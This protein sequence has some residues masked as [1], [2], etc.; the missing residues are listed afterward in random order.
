MSC[1]A[2][3]PGS[4][5]S[6]TTGQGSPPPPPLPLEP[7]SALSHHPPP[8]SATHSL[9]QS[10]HFK[11]C[12]GRPG[13]FDQCM[14]TQGRNRKEKSMPL[15]DH[16][17]SLLR[18]Q[19]RAMETQHSRLGQPSRQPSQLPV[20]GRLWSTACQAFVMGGPAA[21]DPPSSGRSHDTRQQEQE[22]SRCLWQ[23]A[24]H[25][26]AYCSTALQH[27][28]ASPGQLGPAEASSA[29]GRLM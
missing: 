25:S 3:R 14:E 19:P 10:I 5:G 11:G 15:S 26:M 21:R 28:I 29:T 18:Q 4:P 13:P 12:W 16:N 2:G 20:A 9:G 1:L 27:R 24:D 17:R 22:V 6:A 7:A 23:A 8:E